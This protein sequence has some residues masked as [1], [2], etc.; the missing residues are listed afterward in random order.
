MMNRMLKRIGIVM[1]S[2]YVLYSTPLQMK[3]E[4]AQTQE[5]VAQLDQVRIETEAN[6]KA[7]AEMLSATWDESKRIMTL[8]K[9]VTL[10]EEIILGQEGSITIDMNGQRLSGGR[11]TIDRKMDFKIIGNG[12]INSCQIKNY[13]SGTVVLA[14]AVTYQHPS[15]EP[16]DMA[17]GTLKIQEGT[18]IEGNIRSCGK[19]YLSGGTVD[20]D[21]KMMINEYHP[22]GQLILSGATL[23]G[24]IASYAVDV[25]IKGGIVNG[26]IKMN[27]DCDYPGTRI[28][29]KGGTINGQVSIESIHP[30]LT[31]TGGIIRSQKSPVIRAGYER[32]MSTAE[33]RAGLGLIQISGGEIV[34]ECKDGIGICVYNTNVK[35]SKGSIKNTSKSGSYGIYSC[36]YTKYA[37]LKKNK[38]NFLIKGFKTPAEHQIKSKYC[39]KDVRYQFDQ[40][41]A[42]LTVSGVGEMFDGPIIPDHIKTSVKHIV[43]SDGVKNV[44]DY[45]F[46]GCHKLKDVVLADSVTAIGFSSFGD[47]TALT[48]VHFPKKLKTIDREAFWHDISLEE[49]IL[50]DS[51]KEIGVQSFWE[52]VKLK[53]LVLSKKLKIIP[54]V[55]FEHCDSLT[56]VTIPDGVTE[57]G[58]AAFAN[59]KKLAQVKMGKNVKLGKGAFSGTPYAK[60]KK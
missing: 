28:Q 12:S 51:V 11:L 23:N 8:Q 16:I 52:C 42:T 14:G 47:C 20:G 53:K 34:S 48:T 29:I 36:T 43:I 15:A 35:L 9:N 7:L 50:P 4:A 55:A 45:N 32:V 39:G 18:T 19:V 6:M 59:C 21:V 46:H 58:Y 13:E 31:M 24:N 44:G 38:E 40:Q 1:L 37:S 60:A 54:D 27:E 17:A 49:V 2:F 25:I 22:R 56:K 33:K 10:K 5:T 30:K 41:T 57:I 3:V 26:D